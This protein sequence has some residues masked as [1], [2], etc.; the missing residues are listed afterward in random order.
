MMRPPFMMVKGDHCTAFTPLPNYPLH[1][2]TPPAH[3]ARMGTGNVRVFLWVSRIFSICR[4][5][6]SLVHFLCEAATRG[7]PHHRGH[8]LQTTWQGAYL[9]GETDQSG[10]APPPATDRVC[11]EYR[12]TLT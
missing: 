7:I 11:Q 6:I 4:M 1:R 10:P 2:G 5:L 9:G 3:K 12:Q 8:D